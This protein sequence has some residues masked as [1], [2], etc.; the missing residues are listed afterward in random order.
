MLALN[1]KKSM[2]TL[3]FFR[4]TKSNSKIRL[5][6]SNSKMSIAQKDEV[7]SSFSEQ[8]I[9]GKSAGSFGTKLV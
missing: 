9:K 6:K 4:L 5:T 1:Q 2:V 7:V 8:K 3:K